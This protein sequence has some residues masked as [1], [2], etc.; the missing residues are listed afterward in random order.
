MQ[1]G[2]EREWLES[3]G[4]GGFSMGTSSLIP[5]RRYHTL[6]TTSLI[7]PTHRFA[8]INTVDAWIIFEGNR[9]PLSSFCYGENLIH[10]RGTYRINSFQPFP[11]PQ[12]NFS[13]QE[14]ELEISHQLFVKK[15]ASIVTLTWK[16]ERGR[17]PASLEVRPLLSVRDYHSLHKFNH[18]FCFDAAYT[19]NCIEWSPY[20]ET[21][22]ISAYSNG[23]YK[24]LPE[25][26]FNFYYREDYLRGYEYNEDLASPGIFH[27]DLSQGEA[28][29]IFVGSKDESFEHIDLHSTSGAV[30]QLRQEENRRRSFFPS[31]L[32]R[33]ADSYIVRRGNGKTVIAGYPWFT[34]WGRDTFISFRG[35]CLSGGR[36]DDGAIV[37]ST[38]I[39]TISQGMIPNRFPDLGLNAEYN[40]VDAS[41]WFVI[42]ADAFIEKT[43]NKYQ[44]LHSRLNKA[45]IEIVSHYY[46]GTRFRIRCDQDSL[47]SSGLQGMQLTWMDAKFNNIVF[48][49]RIGKPVEIQALWINALKIA[50]KTESKWNDIFELALNSFKAKFWNKE[51]EMLYDV[52][53]VD[54]EANVVDSTIR[55][56][57]IFA[58]GGLPLQLLEESMAKKVLAG[59]EKELL[60]P[61]GLRTL[62]KGDVRFATKYEGDQYDRDAS[63]HQGTVWPWLLGPFVEAWV[64]LYK[65]P[66]QAKDQYLT[67]ILDSVNERS[68]IGHLSEIH[69]AI[70][71]YHSRGC[72]FQAWSVAEIL[73]I[74]YDVLQAK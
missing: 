16:Q 7:P 30:Q 66:V 67:E 13:F 37:L 8:L 24:H 29:L 61:Y 73:R 26:Y 27:W 56:N 23:S 34:D 35:I 17:S 20:R 9:Y 53:D 36:I 59:I 54:H 12:W 21:P 69:D 33:A 74:F 43:T 64:R 48:T 32:H 44:D 49:P 42:A 50:G 18:N 28:N 71:P 25:W 68:G 55:P 14:L 60:T 45:I 72:P 22:T 4:L 47:L 19:K 15:G 63:Y 39:D 52:I 38:W 57:Q 1:I 2:Q 5:R 40:S 58:I 6:L 70:A 31:P 51:N 65:N 41:L 10:P 62:N 46:H 11:W 3:D